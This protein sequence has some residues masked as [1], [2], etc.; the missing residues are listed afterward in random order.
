MFSILP[1]LFWLW[2]YLREDRRDPEPRSLLFRLFLFGIIAGA[3]GLILETII[4]YAFFDPSVISDENLLSEDETPMKNLPEK[5]AIYAVI[6]PLMEEASKYIFIKRFGFS[7][8]Y[9]NQII[10]GVIYAVTVSLGLALFENFLYFTEFLSKGAAVFAGGFVLR[11]LF[12]T[13]LHTLSTG[14]LGY[15]MGRGKFEVAFRTKYLAF[16]FILAVLIHGTFNLL[17]IT[18]RLDLAL[19]ALIVVASLL[20]ERLRS[21]RS[22]MFWYPDTKK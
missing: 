8:K 4:L 13:L 22:Q 11:F 15:W 18:A 21:A 16:G 5:I 14:W 19:L 9:F 2:I 20:F 1:S 3:L 7:S 10:D 12:S 17:M 6:A